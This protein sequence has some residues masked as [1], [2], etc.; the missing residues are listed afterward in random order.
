MSKNMQKKNIQLFVPKYN[1]DECL[2]SIRECLEIGW[3]GLG[4]KTIDL[5]NRWKEY[6]SLNNAHFLNSATAGLHLATEIL[7]E[8]NGWMDEDEIITTPTTFVSSNHA[9]LYSNLKPIFADID[10][11]GCIS[12]E[13]VIQKITSK[14]RAIMFVGLG[15]STGQYEEIVKICREHDLK[16]IL[17]AAHMAGTYLNGRIPGN[18][19]DVVIY[20]FQAVKNMPTFDSGM[21]CFK[22]KKYDDIAR[23]KA[24][25]GIDKDTFSRAENSG[26]YK[27]KYDVPYV[28]YKYNGNSI[29]AS[30]G[31]VQLKCL[32]KDN[33]Y[34][35]SLCDVYDKILCDVPR[36]DRVRIPKNCKSSRHLYQVLVEDRD[37]VLVK[38]NSYGIYPGVHYADNTNYHPYSYAQ[39]TCPKAKKYSEQVISLPLHLNLTV[40]DVEY[41]A[42][43]LIQIIDAAK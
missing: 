27:W 24:W 29:A 10:D 9:I 12:P 11:Y 13:S 19:S 39:N 31:L 3:T 28:G 34:R 21:I 17:D 40:D 32:D 25:L 5:E 8:E 7:K 6:T 4:F 33:D 2:E 30:V 41:V 43:Q 1:V 26:T 22:E 36:I 37:E 23:K 18:E 15:G 16:L 20:S 35:R 14:T 42:K 38:L